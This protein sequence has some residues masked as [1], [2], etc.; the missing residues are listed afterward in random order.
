MAM[1]GI[2]K[3]KKI[4]RDANQYVARQYFAISLVQPMHYSQYQR[5]FRGYNRQ[6]FAVSAAS[7]VI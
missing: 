1:A 7:G 4:I 2:D 5:W 3:I 6:F